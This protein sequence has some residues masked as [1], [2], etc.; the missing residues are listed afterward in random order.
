MCF[1]ASNK[2]CIVH[3]HPVKSAFALSYAL[4]KRLSQGGPI[5]FFNL[6][7]FHNVAGTA[8]AQIFKLHE[9]FFFRFK[10][11][12]NGIKIIILRFII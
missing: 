3:L 6:R 11:F 4:L 12:Q 5:S 8:G 1:G 7:R 2:I 9:M 10:P